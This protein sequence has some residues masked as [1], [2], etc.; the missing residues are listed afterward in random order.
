[1]VRGGSSPL[2]RTGKAPHSGAF[3]MGGQRAAFRP[4]AEERLP[5]STRRHP[6]AT[7]CG[8]GPPTSHRIDTISRSRIGGPP[9][10]AARGRSRSLALAG[11]LGRA[12]ISQIVAARLQHRLDPDAPGTGQPCSVARRALG[13]LAAMGVGH[14]SVRE[15][16]AERANHAGPSGLPASLIGSAVRAWLA[17]ARRGHR[18]SEVVDAG[19][20]K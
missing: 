4:R 12:P 15:S 19:V 13:R 18:A 14:R 3:F 8:Y 9:V 16:C 17:R 10:F 20:D 6:F 1:M 7:P 11:Q 2:G 5:R